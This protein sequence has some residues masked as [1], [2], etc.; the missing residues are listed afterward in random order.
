M[1]TTEYRTGG[2]RK[3]SS[4]DRY[5]Y[6]RS[7]GLVGI[8]T[9]ILRQFLFASA[10]MDSVVEDKQITSIYKTLRIASLHREGGRSK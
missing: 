2:I 5:N 9:W 10:P 3:H 8:A 4:T 6:F 1:S 7:G